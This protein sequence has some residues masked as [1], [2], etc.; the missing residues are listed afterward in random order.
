M[1]EF[2]YNINLFDLLIIPIIL[3]SIKVSLIVFESIVDTIKV[4]KCKIRND[5]DDSIK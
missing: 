1:F 5:H 4:I 2:L 3:V